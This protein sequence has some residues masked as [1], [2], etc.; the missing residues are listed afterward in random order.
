MGGSTGN[1]RSGEPALLAAA[2]GGDENAFALLVEP[3]RGELHAH[4]YRML[5][6]LHD[7]ED[8]LQETLLRAWRGLAR[9]E[10]R[11]SLRSWLYT[12]ATNTSLNA[13]EHRGRRIHPVD[14]G[15]PSDPADGPG[16]PLVE[17]AWIE[18]YPDE[19]LGL[20]DGLASPEARYERR[21]AVELA[22]IAALQL[23]PPNQRAALILREVLGYSA[24]EV[25]ATLETSEAAVNSALQRARRTVEERLPERS[26]LATIRALGDEGVREVVD[27]YVEA[28]DRRDI[29]GVVSMLTEDACFS[30]PPLRSWYGG[31]AGPAQMAEFMRVGPL[32]GEWDWRHPLVQANGQPALGFYSWYE[33]DQTYRPF[34][35]NVLS[36]RGERISDVTCFGCRSIESED[37]E[38]YARWPEEPID[39]R[40][41]RDYFLR[42]GL[43]ERIA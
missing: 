15:P 7:A 31:E 12:I 26:Q 23:L 1:R 39:E 22:F 8:A 14:L 40:R 37:R 3:Y 24:R 36:L 34:A 33:P 10:R 43:P 18:P 6:S 11:S 42:F 30:M 13:I 41:M 9:F 28:W 27:A 20:D 29:D 35:L 5:G 2:G 16:E 4:C 21:E 17:S 19:P 25:A 32:S 38:A